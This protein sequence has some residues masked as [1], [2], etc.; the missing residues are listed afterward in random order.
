MRGGDEVGAWDLVVSPV[1][2]ARGAEGTIRIAGPCD[3]KVLWIVPPHVETLADDGDT[4]RFRLGKVA[5]G[6]LEFAAVSVEGAQRYG[7]ARVAVE[8][9]ALFGTERVT[10][11]GVASIAPQIVWHAPV[12][13]H[14]GTSTR[15]IRLVDGTTYQLTAVASVVDPLEEAE[16]TVELHTG[17][18]VRARPSRLVGVRDRFT[19]EATVIGA[20]PRW[21]R[22]T[23]RS[24]CGRIATSLLVSSASPTSA[25]HDEERALRARLAGAIQHVAAA[26]IVGAPPPRPSIADLS[27]ELFELGERQRASVAAELACHVPRHDPQPVDEGDWYVEATVPPDASP[28][29]EIIAEGTATPE[30]RAIPCASVGF[31]LRSQRFDVVEGLG[32]GTRTD[33]VVVAPST[34]RLKIELGADARRIALYRV[35]VAGP[36]HAFL[37]PGDRATTARFNAIV[38]G[39]GSP[40]LRWEIVEAP[41]T[42]FAGRAPV[43]VPVDGTRACELTPHAPGRYVIAVRASGTSKVVASQAI[44]V[45]AVE[46]AHGPARSV[47]IRGLGGIDGSEVE[48]PITG[49]FDVARSGANVRARLQSVVL[50]AATYDVSSL[51]CEA[52]APVPSEV[53]PAEVTVDGGRAD[54]IAVACGHHREHTCV[55]RI[56]HARVLGWS[57]RGPGH[58]RRMDRGDEP[59]T[60]ELRIRPPRFTRDDAE[61]V[62]ELDGERRRI[63]I[64]YLPPAIAIEAADPGTIAIRIVHEGT[65][66]AGCDVR[67]WITRGSVRASSS[68]TLEV[69]AR[70][71]TDDDGIARFVV[72]PN[73][74]P[75]PTG[76]WAARGGDSVLVVAVPGAPPALHRITFD[77]PAA[78]P[79]VLDRDGSRARLA[80]P[81]IA[82]PIVVQLATA[83]ARPLPSR[84]L[85]ALDVRR[86]GPHVDDAALPAPHGHAGARVLIASSG[87]AA[88]ALQVPSRLRF[89]F[90]FWLQLSRDA[91]WDVLELRERESGLA[92]I[93]SAR[94]G[95]LAIRSQDGWPMLVQPAIAIPVGLWRRICLDVERSLADGTTTLV[96]RSDRPL[97]VGTVEEARTSALAASRFGAIASELA[98]RVG[99]PHRGDA[100]VAGA[101]TDLLYEELVPARGGLMPGRTGEARF[102]AGAPPLDVEPDGAATDRTSLTI[103]HARDASVVATWPVVTTSAELDGL[104]ATLARHV[105]FVPQDHARALSRALA[106]RLAGSPIADALSFGP[107]VGADARLELATIAT[108]TS[109]HA[110]AIAVLR[111]ILAAA[112]EQGW[113]ARAAGCTEE[114]ILVEAMRAVRVDDRGVAAPRTL[115][116]FV[117]ADIPPE[118]WGELAELGTALSLESVSVLANRMGG[119]STLGTALGRI[120]L[121]GWFVARG[122]PP[123]RV[124]VWVDAVE[125]VRARI[126]T[127]FPQLDATLATLKLLRAR[128]AWTAP[129]LDLVQEGG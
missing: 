24:A 55:L 10:S 123:E 19:F 104:A 99:I 64:D 15:S 85:I 79:I 3:Q 129:L 117:L 116:G 46:V 107:G 13:S 94:A 35:Q 40:Q 29:L 41:A 78:D 12:T 97:P 111:S 77:L 124:S 53:L 33:R 92:C 80:L 32:A 108:P 66:I 70:A 48:G 57:L 44:D 121:A 56:R 16:F 115:T 112:L 114:T 102:D 25:D 47:L 18:G 26:S 60:L 27:S 81:P 1:T 90:A 59:G 72:S 8:D 17:P 87:T 125:A 6:V 68:T 36:R 126:A 71:V 61:L 23:A 100:G 96:L 93:V 83:E 110:I 9:L 51:A 42:A 30:P 103:A 50:G 109:P 67:V 62:L 28:T 89:R 37:A 91:E 4:L 5:C 31:T 127:A 34:D 21:I 54:R 58:A 128:H 76:A 113:P 88:A 22:V 73:V 82:A 65:P 39:G 38:T 120:V 98:V 20:G 2:V 45:Y 75:G 74:P 52:I 43:L 63:P 105:A 84:R 14:A 7:V 49:S 106:G 118:R 101:I 119:S 95:M 122:L 11:L 69:A 86:A